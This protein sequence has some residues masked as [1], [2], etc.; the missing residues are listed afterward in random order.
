MFSSQMDKCLKTK[1]QINLLPL[2]QCFYHSNRNQTRTWQALC[3]ASDGNG[4]WAAWRVITND[5]RM[6]SQCRMAGGLCW[7]VALKTAAKTGI[8][9]PLKLLLGDLR[10]TSRFS[11]C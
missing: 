11:G 7:D 5:E 1:S 4:S 6:R 2:S 8:P 10:V 3:R 9:G